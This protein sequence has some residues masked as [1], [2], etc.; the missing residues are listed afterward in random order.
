VVV[1]INPGHARRAEKAYYKREGAKYK[2]VEQYWHRSIT[3]RAYYKK[4]RELMKAFGLDGPILWTELAKCENSPGTKSPPLKTL[5]SCTGRFLTQELELIPKEWPLIGVGR[6]ACQALAYQYPA[7]T[8][9]G[10]PHP[11]GAYGNKFSQISPPGGRLYSKLKKT[12]RRALSNPPGELLWI[13]AGGG[14]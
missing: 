13:G 5:R 3:I 4:L 10:V 12:V 1:G 7:R 8:V 14:L 6:E 11:T 2:V 9:I